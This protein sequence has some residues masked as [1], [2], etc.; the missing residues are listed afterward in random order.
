MTCSAHN[1]RNMRWSIRSFTTHIHEFV[2]FSTIIR[3][4]T[5]NEVIVPG[6][7]LSSVVITGLSNGIYS[8]VQS[9]M[10]VS[11]SL[12]QRGGIT[13]ICSGSNL[14]NNNFYNSFFE[15]ADIVS[16]DDDEDY[17]CKFQVAIMITKNFTDVFILQFFHIGQCNIPT[18]LHTH[19]ILV[20][21]II[22]FNLQYSFEHQTC[23]FK[24][25]H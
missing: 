10:T 1:V 14:D 7:T 15:Q 24:F 8:S 20:S 16:N 12:R 22:Y 3:S 17:P 4:A 21:G 9:T 18:L 6:I 23:H 11:P 2:D 25:C 13:F 19:E 5:Q